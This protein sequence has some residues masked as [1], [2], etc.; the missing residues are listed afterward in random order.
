M[1]QLN[2]DSIR[3]RAGTAGPSIDGNF[4]IN[5]NTT[6]SG[7]L[8]LNQHLRVS[9]IVTASSFSSASGLNVSGTV[10]ATQLSSSVATGTAPL[11]VNSTTLVSNLNADLL[12]GQSGSFYQNAGNLNAGTIPTARLASGTA[13]ADSFLRG[14]QTWQSITSYSDYGSL[15]QVS[16]GTR[17]SIS[18]I[19]S[20]N[21][22]YS[23]A[24][25]GWTSSG[26]WTTFYTY[27]NNGQQDAEAAAWMGLGFQPNSNFGPYNSYIYN[28]KRIQLNTSGNNIGPQSH[29]DLM[30]VN[31]NT[32]SYSPVS[33]LMTPIRNNHPTLTKSVTI[34]GVYSSYWSSGYDGSSSW[35]YIPGQTGTYSGVTS[36]TWSRKSSVTGN[37]TSGTVYSWTQSIP[38]DTTIVV[39][40]LAS[41]LYYTNNGTTYSGFEMNKLYDLAATF[42]DPWIQVDSR[43]INTMLFADWQRY[44]LTATNAYQF[45]KV[46]NACADMY[47]NR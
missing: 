30:W 26:P 11:T 4:N 2:V 23:D 46:Y 18:S 39:M 17:K 43:M 29:H 41:T 28:Q 36:G 40:S 13:N 42:S 16:G 10:S 31:S 12:D 21:S 3:N 20:Y 27:G 14:D 25:Y 22:R 19:Y 45:F 5:G 1:S 33:I 32:Y 24:Y 47:G 38:A 15:E 34:N 35:V 7:S 8:V 6:S 9:G 37:N 44:G